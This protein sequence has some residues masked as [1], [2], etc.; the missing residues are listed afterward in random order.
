[1]R[2][3]RDAALRRLWLMLMV[4]IVLPILIFGYAAWINYNA[5]FHLADER[6]EH[7]LDI[8]TEQALR[9]FQSVTV[10]FDSVDQITRGRVSLT[11]RTNEAIRHGAAGHRFGLGPRCRWNRAGIFAVLPPA[12]RRQCTG[13]RL[14]ESSARNG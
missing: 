9:V 12:P 14:P 5:A 4:S 2:Q 3:R 11:I 10:T 7:A 13:A 8:A 6:I 1:M